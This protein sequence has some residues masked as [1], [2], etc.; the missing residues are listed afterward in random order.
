MIN[1]T[2][3]EKAYLAGIFDGEG[4][5]GYYKANG[6]HAIYV[7]ITNTDS[8]VISW[9]VSRIDYGYVKTRK[10]HVNRKPVWEWLIRNRDN[11][12]EFLNTIKP[13]LVIKLDQVDLLLSLMNDERLLRGDKKKFQ[14]LSPEIIERRISVETQ[15][16]ALKTIVH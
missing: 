6:S 3:T 7:Q 10:R 16:K 5:I 2:E 11:A 13:Y 15:M 8:R 1:L 14:S 4:N 12:I 9:L